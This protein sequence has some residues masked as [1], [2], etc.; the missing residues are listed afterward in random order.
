VV[1]PE[2]PCSEETNTFNFLF[3]VKRTTTDTSSGSRDTN[4]IRP[5]ARVLPTNENEALACA[6]YYAPGS[7]KRQ[8]RLG[9]LTG[10]AV[11]G[12]G[13]DAE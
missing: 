7:V 4:G 11:S 10:T 3:S 6:E 5:L 2:V 8:L 13:P 12:I 9:A 1:R